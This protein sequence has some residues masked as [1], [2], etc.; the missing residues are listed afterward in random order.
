[1]GQWVFSLNFLFELLRK[2]NQMSLLDNLPHRCTIR[3]LKLAKG[4]LGGSKRTPTVEQTNVECWDQPASAKEI[5]EFQKLGM[6]I[7]RKI[8]FK[9]DP[10]VTEA[11]DILITSR[12]RGTT[13]I[14]SPFPLEVKSESL[15]DASAGLGVLFRVMVWQQ[16]GSKQ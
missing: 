3:V 11:H 14:S 13:T 1:L 2:K 8:Y 6:G 10:G 9:T 15:P 16:T 7:N 4:T 12:D 5:E